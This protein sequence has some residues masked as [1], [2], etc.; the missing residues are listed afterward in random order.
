M[1]SRR[2]EDQGRVRHGGG[3]VVQESVPPGW[4]FPAPNTLK[5]QAGVGA[6]GG[7]CLQI[8]RCALPE[9]HQRGGP[10]A[11]SGWSAAEA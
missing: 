10:R 2:E 1:T 6:Q 5:F 8:P 3:S 9:A 11:P 4:Q 7:S